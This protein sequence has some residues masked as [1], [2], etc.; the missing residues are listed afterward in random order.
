MEKTFKE[1]N[2][3]QLVYDLNNKSKTAEDKMNNFVICK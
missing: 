3:K 2:E 1:N